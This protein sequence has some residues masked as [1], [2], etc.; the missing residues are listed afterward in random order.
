MKTRTRAW[1]VWVSER[2]QVD[3][4]EA[5]VAAHPLETGGILV[6]VIGRTGK[7]GN[8]PW[9]THAVA[10]ASRKSGLA[11]YEL[12]AQARVRAVM[13]LRKGDSRLGYLGDWHSHPANVDPSWTDV[14]AIESISISGDCPRPLLFVIRRAQGGYVIDARQWTGAS[15]RHLQVC[16]AGPL[17]RPHRRRGLRQVLSVFRGVRLAA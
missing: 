5:S 4:L 1:R 13:Q 12:P 8:R 17:P 6:G 7:S 9:V 14:S 10:V 16:D 2:A 3:M 15:L 11:H